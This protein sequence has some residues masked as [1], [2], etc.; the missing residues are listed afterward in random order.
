[1]KPQS[2]A[3]RIAMFGHSEHSIAAGMSLAERKRWKEWL[4]AK[5]SDSAAFEAQLAGRK[6]R[7]RDPYGEV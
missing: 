7:V 5:Q 4:R 1:M 3:Q 2:E 6:H